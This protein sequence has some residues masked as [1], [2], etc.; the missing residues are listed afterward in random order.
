[1]MSKKTGKRSRRARSEKKKRDSPGGST[2]ERQKWKDVEE[3]KAK[4]QPEVIYYTS[5]THMHPPSQPS[6]SSSLCS[7]YTFLLFFLLYIKASFMLSCI[8]PLSSFLSSSL[9]SLYAFGW[10]HDVLRCK[11]HDTML[12]IGHASSE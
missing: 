9:Q 6:S 1:M 4:T 3:R 5:N 11:M 2:K 7:H 8:P 12:F 10:G